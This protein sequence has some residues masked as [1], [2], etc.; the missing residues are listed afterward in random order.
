MT[1]ATPQSAGR[2]RSRPARRR[3]TQAVLTKT[4]SASLTTAATLGLVVVIADHSRANSPT[5][6][7]AIDA[8][9]DAA[10]ALPAEAMLDEP[11]T[12]VV[13][14]LDI[15]APESA[16]PAASATH[17]TSGGSRKRTTRTPASTIPTRTATRTTTRP[18]TRTTTTKRTVTRT[19]PKRVTTSQ[20]R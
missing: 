1:D 7:D 9:G 6:V 18:A 13:I 2:P 15:P 17:R 4:V 3:S 14:R 16:Q 20:S 5:V 12:Q 8:A 19:A 11:L 10:D